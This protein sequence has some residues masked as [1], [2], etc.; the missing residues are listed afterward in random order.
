MDRS[1][2]L[3]EQLKTVADPRPGEPVYPLVNI[4]FMTICA[5]IAG[6]DDYD[7][8]AKLANTKKN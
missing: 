8:I 2:S 6:A 7:A 5:V 4:L 3:V 1:A